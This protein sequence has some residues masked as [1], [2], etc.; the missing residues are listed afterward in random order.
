MKLPPCIKGFQILTLGPLAEVAV[1]VEVDGKESI[2]R[3]D[4]GDSLIRREFIRKRE[5]TAEYIVKIEDVND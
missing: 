4:L 2:I 3:K 1:Q 5:N